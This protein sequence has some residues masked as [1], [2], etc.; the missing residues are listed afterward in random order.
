MVKSTASAQTGIKT[1]LGSVLENLH[2][3]TLFGSKIINCIDRVDLN[4][5]L[6][7]SELKLLFGNPLLTGQVNITFMFNF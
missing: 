6:Y 1:I 4:S 5:I 2:C 7:L 3:R